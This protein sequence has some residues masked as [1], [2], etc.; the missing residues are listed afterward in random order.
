MKYENI[1]NMKLGYFLGNFSPAI[2][3]SEN[4]EMAIKSYNFGNYEGGYYR[5]TDTEIF[6]VLLGKV[7]F[8]GKV[9]SK[10]GMIRY[11]PRE[12]KHVFPVEDSQ[13]LVVRFP[14][15]KRDL[16]YRG[17]YDLDV[18]NRQFSNLSNELFNSG[19]MQMPV[20]SKPIQPNEVSVIVQG[21]IHKNLTPACLKSVRKSLPG[22]KIILSTWEGSDIENLDFDQIVLSKD[23][24]ALECNIQKEYPIINNGNRQLLSIKQGLKM[25]Q[26]KYVLKLRTDLA[27]MGDDIL[28]FMNS[29]PKRTNEYPLFNSRVIIGELFTRHNFYF[30][31]QGEWHNVPKPF[32]PSDWFMLGETEDI[33]LYFEN[34]PLIPDKDLGN[35]S[36]K[37]PKRCYDNKYPWSWRYATEQYYCYEAFRRKYPE[38]KFDDWT[39]Y[40]DEKIIISEKF[41]KNNFIILNMIEHR[42]CN[43]KYMTACFRNW[44]LNNEE[45]DLIDN[46][47]FVDSYNI[48]D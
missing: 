21:A 19:R 43:L 7:E 20:K 23:P 38:V 8:N 31:T 36:L 24:G 37:Y 17:E 9:L 22:A 15:T 26:T 34:T 28:Y 18:L 39:D 29:F 47:E 40:D 32:H 1:E 35:F 6:V 11:E 33:R 2:F 45:K 3:N 44:G 5:K 13:C 10:G 27:M 46:Q 16:H 30:H 42:I 25:V 41:I 48:L 4:V 12:V 14:G